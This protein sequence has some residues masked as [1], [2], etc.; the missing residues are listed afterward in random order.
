MNKIVSI[1]MG[2]FML[3]SVGNAASFTD[4][5]QKWICT[6]NASESTVEADKVADDIMAHTERAAMIVFKNALDHC[7]D[8]TKITC[9]SKN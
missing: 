6:T 7:R 9:E 2:T 1:M 3:V 5:G 8:C 4:P